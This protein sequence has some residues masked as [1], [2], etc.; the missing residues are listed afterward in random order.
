MNLQNDF[1]P[2]QSID[3]TCLFYLRWIEPNLKT[4]SKK[5][6]NEGFWTSQ[7][8]QPAWKSWAGYAFESICYKH[9]DQIRHALNID[10]GSIAGTWRYSPRAKENLEGAQ[11]DLLFDRPDG[12]I[13]ICEIKSSDKAFTIDKAY[14]HELLKKMEIFRKHTK[15]K[16][17]LF[18]SMVTTMG[19]NPSMYSEEIIA[20]QATLED[21]F[22]EI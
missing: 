5:A 17:Q 11:I 14:C 10:L 15:T 19:L 6:T 3:D 8:N 9:I 4:I 12:V 20:N 18:L 21:L 13:T 16:K 7:S 22:T 1:L 2:L